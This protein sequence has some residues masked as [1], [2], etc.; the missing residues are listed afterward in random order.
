M[1][2]FNAN[3][4]NYTYTRRGSNELHDAGMLILVRTLQPHARLTVTALAGNSGG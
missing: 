4:I 3:S 2:T 1:E